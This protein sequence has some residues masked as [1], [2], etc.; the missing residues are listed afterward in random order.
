M[1]KRQTL[2]RVVGLLASIATASCG[3]EPTGPPPGPP[4]A[5]SVVVLSGDDQTSLPT[6]WLP[7]SI[8]IQVLDQNGLPFASARV[9]VEAEDGGD[10]EQNLTSSGPDGRVTI[11]WRLGSEIGPQ[12]L[13]VLV[14]G[15]SGPSTVS[16]NA[17]Q[18]DTVDLVHVSGAPGG[19]YGALSSGT[20]TFGNVIDYGSTSSSAEAAAGDFRA[21]S[22]VGRS[23][24]TFFSPDVP[25]RLILDPWTDEPDVVETSFTDPLEVPVTVWIMEEP[26]DSTVERVRRDVDYTEYVYAQEALGIVFDLEIVDATATENIDSLMV[27]TCSKATTVEETVGHR[28]NRLNLYYLTTVDGGSRRGVACPVGGNFVAMAGHAGAD[29]LSHE[30]GH[31]FG[32]SH[33]DSSESFG[34]TNVMHSSSS[35]RRYLSEGQVFRAHW[36]SRSALNN[37]LGTHPFEFVRDCLGQFE[38]RV[39]VS[40]DTRLFADEE[41][42]VAAASIE[43]VGN[44]SRL[45]RALLRECNTGESGDIDRGYD[46]EELLEV[47]RN[48]PSPAFRMALESEGNRTNLPGL[49]IAIRE[50][51]L[52]LLVLNDDGRALSTLDEALSED[53]EF[54]RGVVQWGR[55]RLIRN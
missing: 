1:Q 6:L 48:G 52:R 4:V 39:C 10:I 37:T 34:R 27:F 30:I 51:A 19:V 55:D 5:T 32:L 46:P 53:P 3:G 18:M 31:M 43:E 28:D 38:D 2:G 24:I 16:A 41:M 25:P 12:S 14:S 11:R 40:V 13:S 49:L 33:I 7:Q 17:A 21:S 42:V 35:V 8:V 15:V 45:E 54:F 36:S 44:L 22:G 26:F 9:T 50:E 47:F 20:T 29:L 23:E